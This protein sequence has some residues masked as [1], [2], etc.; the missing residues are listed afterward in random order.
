M[1]FWFLRLL[2]GVAFSVKHTFGVALN[3]CV[4]TSELAQKMYPDLKPADD[5]TNCISLGVLAKRLSNS[6]LADYVEGNWDE[7][8]TPDMINGAEYEALANIEVFKQLTKSKPLEDFYQGRG[9][10]DVVSNDL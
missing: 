4:D 8:P 6:D 1:S 5:G 9:G 7:I 2:T 10:F 3:S